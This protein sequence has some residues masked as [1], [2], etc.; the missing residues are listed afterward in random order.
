MF[1][2]ERHDKKNQQYLDQMAERATARAVLEGPL[3]AEILVDCSPCWHI[4]KIVPANERRAQVQ[5][6]ARK[7]GVYLPTFRDKKTKRV[8]LLVPG[9]LFLFV[10]DV[11]FHW[12]RIR[13]CE[14]VLGIMLDGGRPAIIDDEEIERLQARENERMLTIDRTRRR[15]RRRSQH[16]NDAVAVH[17]W[18]AFADLDES[19]RENLLSKA[20]GI[21]APSIARS[22]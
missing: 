6:V 19:R 16:D 11:K 4:L 7:F 13:S 18:S 1:G 14:G 22:L 10:W 2:D 20:L 3:D 17:S 8:K 5:L 9:Y 12:K 21:A 15:R